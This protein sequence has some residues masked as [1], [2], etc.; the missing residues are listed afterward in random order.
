MAV[1]ILAT[2]DYRLFDTS[3]EVSKV[4]FSKLTVC[5][6]VLQPIFIIT[7]YVFGI[8]TVLNQ[9]SNRLCFDSSVWV[10]STVSIQ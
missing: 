4:Y 10:D 3:L 8:Q 6:A 9:T 2:A 1:K 5:M 7:M